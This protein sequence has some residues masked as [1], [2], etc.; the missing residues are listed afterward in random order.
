MRAS[1]RVAPSERNTAYASSRAA[2]TSGATIVSSSYKCRTMPIRNPRE[3]AGERRPVIRDRAARTRRIFRI[4]TGYGLQNDR[5]IFDGPSHWTGM[6]EGER[7]SIDTGAT[8]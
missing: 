5:T 3:V 2:R 8:D 7:V 4:V 6:I 1:S